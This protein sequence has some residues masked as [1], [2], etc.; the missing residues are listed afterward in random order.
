MTRP[1]SY[2]EP[3]N[4]RGRIGRE[5][6]LG[7]P[8]INMG[9]N[10]LP[11]PPTAKVKAAL[12]QRLVSLGSYG[13]P[14]CDKLRAALAQENGLREE[15]IMCGNGSEELIDVIARNFLRPGDDMV[16]S[17]FGYIQF[18]MTAHRIGAG[19]VKAAEQNL[20]TDIDA[21]L[22]AV[23]E[24]TK[25]IFLANPNNPTGTMISP[26][27]LAE[28]AERLPTH[29]VLVLDLAYGEFADHAYPASV[30]GL[31]NQH[32]N[33]V[34]LRT[35]SKAFGLAG[36]RVGW[37]YA[38]DWM[39]P[40]FYAARGMGSVNA[41]AQSAAE[42]ALQE[43]DV[44]RARVDE[45]VQERDRIAS[46]LRQFGMDVVPSHTNFLLIRPSSADPE[47]TEALVEH[48]FAT[49]GIIVNRTREA[50]LE[51]YLRFSLSLP[52]HNDLLLRGVQTFLEKR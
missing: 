21:V 22:D 28:L 3:L 8:I 31:V 45:I 14:A 35:F 43:M 44:I 27:K 51:S 1:K 38:P 2:L 25:V 41:L 6:P 23:T 52:E 26:D 9:F 39:L 20:T 19:V 34:V 47:Q 24:R 36:V 40:G 17:E 11:Y 33:V 12:E 48:L 50:G 16:I 18:L 7:L 30:H 5:Q 37:A 29:V 15:Q 32:E 13:S 42:A 10:E 49:C 46:V 4:V